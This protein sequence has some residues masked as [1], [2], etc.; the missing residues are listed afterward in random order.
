MSGPRRAHSGRGAAKPAPL[1]LAVCLRRSSAPALSCGESTNLAQALE[2]TD[3]NS[4]WFDAGIS[5]GRN[6]IVR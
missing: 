3:S 4:G 1:V 5:G 2:V 6:K